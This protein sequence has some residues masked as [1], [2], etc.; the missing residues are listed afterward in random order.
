MHRIALVLACLCGVFLMKSDANQIDY[1][2]CRSIQDI[3]VRESQEIICMPFTDHDELSQLYVSRGESYLLDAQYEKAIDD[4]VTADYHMS[5]SQNIHTSTVVAF[6]AAFGKSVGYDNLGMSEHAQQALQHLKAIADYVD[7]D[8]C[9]KDRP[10]MDARNQ[11]VNSL[12]FSDIASVSKHKKE[13]HQKQESNLDNYNDI[14][15]PNQVPPNW[16]EEVVTG[17]GRAM[18]AIAC[19]AKNYGVKI[20]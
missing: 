18:D 12:R 9:L 16:C 19:L 6:R 1:S 4:F 3:I 11:T 14:Q 5:F 15:G 10:C 7:C 2:E 8:D 13:N 17:V 20:F